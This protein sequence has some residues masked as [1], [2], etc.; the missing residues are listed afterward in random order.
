MSNNGSHVRNRHTRS[1]LV[2]TRSTHGPSGFLGPIEGASEVYEQ[3]GIDGVLQPGDIPPG[4]VLGGALVPGTLPAAAFASTIRPVYLVT[5][6]PTLP[7]AAY[8]VG[9]FVYKTNDVPPRM[10]K[11]VADVWVAAIGPDD[12]QA[13]SITA[14]QIAAGAVSTSE[15]AV[16]ARLTGEVANETGLTPGVFIDSSGILIRQGKLVL[17]DEFAQTVMVASGFSGAWVDY[18]QLGLYNARFLSGIVGTVPLGRTAALPYW[19]LGNVAGSPV[20]TFL[21]GG[22]VRFTFTALAD[23]KSIRSDLVSVRPDVE[24]AT[25]MAWSAVIA[26]GHINISP[27]IYWFQGDGVTPSVTPSTSFGTYGVL[28]T[29]GIDNRDSFLVVSPTDAR[30][31]RLHYEVDQSVH[32]ASNSVT[33]VSAGLKEAP[34]RLLINVDGDESRY[35][36]FDNVSAQKLDV[37]RVLV[38]GDAFPLDPTSLYEQFYRT[39]LNMWFYFDGTRWLSTQLFTQDLTG[40]GGI[41][42]TT[43]DQSR[44]SGPPD[45]G[46]DIWLESWGGGYLINGGSALSALNKWDIQLGTNNTGSTTFWATKTISSG[47]SSAWRRDADVAISDLAGNDIRYFYLSA[48][49]TGAPGGLFYYGHVNYRIVAM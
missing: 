12:I 48:T 36:G 7:D 45:L 17:Q 33:F 10:Y 27:T 30:F 37:G 23:R 35:F 24:Y 1:S 46:T 6:L 34:P 8:P 22:G 38:G 43:G 2:N 15:L 25:P 40:I 9:Q 5:T 28:V 49:K 39:D 29:G 42:V 20:A 13:N 44:V 16:G 14:G 41:T 4:T 3:I 19:T 26:A 18:V 21:S 31:A 11:N 32:S 47:A